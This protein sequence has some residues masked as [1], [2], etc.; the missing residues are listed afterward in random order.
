M[1]LQSNCASFASGGIAHLENMTADAKLGP[2]VSRHIKNTE[3][4]LQKIERNRA[5]DARAMKH[6]RSFGWT[7]LKLWEHETAERIAETIFSAVETARAASPGVRRPLEHI[8]RPS[9]EL[10]VSMATKR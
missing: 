9:G 6:L 10:E 1:T 2:T 8:E 5:R 3:F 7:V 4:W